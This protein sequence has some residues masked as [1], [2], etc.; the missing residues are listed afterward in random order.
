MEYR[1]GLFQGFHISQATVNYIARHTCSASG[2]SL[3]F[4]ED[5][6]LVG[7]FL[8]FYFQGMLEDSTSLNLGMRKRKKVSSSG[9]R[10]SSALPCCKVSCCL[11]SLLE[12]TLSVTY[13]AFSLCPWAIGPSPP[14]SRRPLNSSLMV[15]LPSSTPLSPFPLVSSSLSLVALSSVSYTYN[16]PRLS[17][18]STQVLLCIIFLFIRL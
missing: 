15:P 16:V 2:Q 10:G 4:L 7:E 18:S 14:R 13:A 5:E 3:L 11:C 8:F 1:V 6:A 12:N 17:L 9:L